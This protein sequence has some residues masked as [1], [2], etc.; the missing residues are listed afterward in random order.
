MWWFC[1][2]FLDVRFLGDCVN[3][4]VVV[5]EWVECIELYLVIIKF[6]SGVFSKF[7]DVSVYYWY[8]EYVWV[9]D[10]YDR[11]F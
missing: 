11:V 1:D 2:G 7:I 9:Y 3:G 6:F 5:R 8:F 4:V 10:V